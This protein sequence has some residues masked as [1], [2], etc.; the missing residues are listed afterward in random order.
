MNFQHARQIA[1]AVLY[2]GYVL[3]PYRASS[4]KNQF[5]WQ[6]GIIAPP[7]YGGEPSEAM[8]ECLIESEPPASPRVHIIVR[9]LQVE[10]GEPG[11][12]KGCER[13]VAVDGVSVEDLLGGERIELFEFAGMISGAI[14]MAAE[15]AGALCKLRVRIEN[16]SDWRGDGRS[17]AIL[18][19]LAGAHTLLGVE[20]G[21]F[22]SLI[23]PPPAAKAAAAACANRH[24]FPVLAGEP[25]ERG[26]MLSSPI[27]LYDYPEIA[28]ES[29][30]DF[31]DATEIDELLTL[32]VMTLTEEERREARATDERA[33]AIIDRSDSI[34]PE[35]FEKLHGAIRQIR[36]SLS[37]GDRV[38]IRP[39]RR[40]DSMDMFL[41]GR[42]ARVEAV[43]RDLENR[44]LVAVVIDDDPA[45]DLHEWYGRY[46][47][48]APD[49][50]EPVGE[51]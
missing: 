36:P 27:I 13:E 4:Q 1:D 21:A 12:D 35:V 8:T 32:R 51:E 48:Y 22:V 39:K 18:R 40:A 33:R 7:G 46:F 11:W 20:Q 41:D 16:R 3:Y 2:E 28:P 38:R 30:G 25:G 23:D 44:P 15:R 45:A 37:R 6:F 10:A 9:F 47:Y 29:P 42:T 24:T 19:S 34:P 14:R 49:E 50:L 31:Y 5:R 43:H 17:E 26:T